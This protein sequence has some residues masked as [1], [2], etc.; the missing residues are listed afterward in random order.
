MGPKK[1]VQQF[2]KSDALIDPEVMAAGFGPGL[3]SLSGIDENYCHCGH[4]P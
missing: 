1:F 4:H 3:C 2:Y